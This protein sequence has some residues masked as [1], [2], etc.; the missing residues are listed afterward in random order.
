[1]LARGVMELVPRCLRGL[2]TAALLMSMA[3]G[4]ALPAQPAPPARPDNVPATPP[5]PAPGT[6]AALDSARALRGAGLQLSVYI[7]GPGQEVFERFGHIAL[8]VADS[9]SGRDVAFNWGMFDFN[10]PNF[11]GRFLTGDTKY[12]MAGYNT[13]EFNAQYQAENRSIRR[14]RLNLTPAQRGALLDYVSWNAEEQNKYYRYDYYNDNCST[15]IRD[16]LDWVL[17]GGV[18]Q[19]WN[20]E[21]NDRT[22]REETARITADDPAVYAGIEVALGRRADRHLTK[23]EEAFLPEHLGNHLAQLSIAGVRV[24]AQDSMLFT[25]Q[26]DPIPDRPPHRELLALVIGLLLAVHLLLLSR[27]PALAWLL[28]ALGSLWYVLGGVLGT[29]LLLAG[30]VTKHAPYMGANLTLLLLNPLLLVT[31][32]FWIWR[33]ENAR[34]GRAGRQ[35]ALVCALLAA[36]ALVLIHFRGFMQGSMQVI[37]LVLPVHAALAWAAFTAP[38]GRSA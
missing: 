10:Q 32:V 19:A 21:G 35:L 20:V 9:A 5:P 37:A 11:L 22:W 38:R 33:R 24:V 8:A 25:A 3:S 29:A 14:L 12:W 17:Q 2:G 6:S 26:R 15:R 34:R 30:T 36:A 7:Y 1:M 18:K 4:S 16:A 13:Y 28:T 31:A 27:M 23:W